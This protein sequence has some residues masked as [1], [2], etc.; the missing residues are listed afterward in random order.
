MDCS[1]LGSSVHGILQARILECVAISFSN[2]LICV[3]TLLKIFKKCTEQYLTLI[4]CN[5]LLFPISFHYVR[6]MLVSKSSFSE[7]VNKNRQISGQAF[8]INKIRNE[9]GEITAN[10]TEI[11]KTIRE[12]YEQLHANKVS[13]P[14]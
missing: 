3:C 6:K 5:A 4:M 7:E 11:Q 13:S 1:L 2:I 12:Y 14:I 8:Q 10:N 9:R